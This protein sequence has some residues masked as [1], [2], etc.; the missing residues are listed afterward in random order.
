MLPQ[1]VSAFMDAFRAQGFQIYLVGGAVRNLLLN[2]KTED[3]DFATNA[4]PDQIL[5]LFPDGFYNNKFGTVGVPIAPESARNAQQ[6]PHTPPMIYEVTTF[7]KESTYTDSRRPDAV[8]WTDS[9]QQDLARRDFTINAMAYDGL[10]LRDPFGGLQDLENKIIRAVGNP[11]IRFA[12]DALRLMRCVRLATVLGFR[13]EP[14]TMRSLS[15]NARRITNISW[16]RIREEFFKILA[17]PQAADGILLLRQC[18]LLQY[19]LPEVEAAFAIDQR[20]PNRHH[21]YDVGTH[22]VESLRHCPSPNVITRFA[23]LIHDI[24]KVPTYRKHAKTG[25]VTFYN[26]EVAG[27]HMAEAIALRFKLSNA[28]REKLVRLVEHHQFTVSE[29]QTDRALRRFIRNVGKENLQDILD[30]RTG[31]RVGSGAKPTSWR[32]E[33]FQKRLEEVQKEPFTVKDLKVDGHDVMRIFAI[34]PSR[35][36]GEILDMVFQEVTEKGLKNDRETLLKRL[37]EISA[38][39]QPAK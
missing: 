1:P 18:G 28:D 20:S 3:W 15:T 33:L 2:G 27:K 19:I 9:L 29:L 38:S 8:E 17:S 34:P 37:Q 25:Q 22:L 14:R 11:D 5:R 6:H 4:T 12:E 31:D 13:V 35:R 32:Y 21:K 16:E 36:V 7:R 24:G 39:K 10:R 30:L 26:H 23:T